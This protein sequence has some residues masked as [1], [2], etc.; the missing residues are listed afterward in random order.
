MTARPRRPLR[1]GTPFRTWRCMCDAVGARDAASQRPPRGRDLEYADKGHARQHARQPLRDAVTGRAARGAAAPRRQPRAQARRPPA[2]TTARPT[3]RRLPREPRHSS[4]FSSSWSASFGVLWFRCRTSCP[5]AA[6]A[7]SRT[8]SRSSSSSCVP[9]C[10][11]RGPRTFP[12]VSRRR[13]VPSRS[14]RDHGDIPRCDPARN[15][16]PRARK[17]SALR[18][19]DPVGHHDGRDLDPDAPAAA[20]CAEAGTRERSRSCPGGPL[21]GSTLIAAA[22]AAAAGAAPAYPRASAASTIRERCTSAT[23]V[24]PGPPREGNGPGARG[25]TSCRPSRTRCCSRRTGQ[26]SAD[27]PSTRPWPSSSPA[28]LPPGRT[29]RRRSSSS[30]RWRRRCRS[31]RSSVVLDGVQPPS[32]LT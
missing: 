32:L 17:R 18:D 6:S 4:R 21:A 9:G 13:P 30:A 28:P 1:R 23:T 26:A 10:R 12:S 2:A 14:R 8:S 15:P 31:G 11:P 3:P 16:H 5:A 29:S 27:S 19:P 20:R 7:H 22:P 24:A 25:L